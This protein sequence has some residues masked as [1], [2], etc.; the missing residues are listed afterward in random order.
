MK[1]P[2][3]LQDEIY[4]APFVPEIWPRLLDRI[5][6]SIG[7]EGALL[8]NVSDPKLPWIASEGVLDLYTAFFRD[9]WAFDNPRT[10][11]LVNIP[12]RGFMSD[13]DHLNEEW[14]ADQAIYRDFLWPQ[15]FGYA[16]GTVIESPG[17]VT[18]AISIDKRRELGPVSRQDLLY[19]DQLRPHL[20][21]AAI[22]AN[23]LEYAKIEAALHALKIVN[24]P[25]ATIRL[26]GRVLATNHLFE[27]YSGKV[28]IGAQDLLHFS[29]AAI[30]NFYQAVVAGREKRTGKS[31][32]LKATD[33]TP[34][35]ILHFFPIAGVAREIFLQVAYFIIITPASPS[36]GTPAEIIKGLFDLTPTESKIAE[37]L[38]RGELISEIARGEGTTVET[39]RSQVKAILSKSGMA[40]Q[41]DF[42]STLG[43][44]QKIEK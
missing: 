43:S 15:G 33:G 37:R 3:L 29:N 1:E 5:S 7:A 13:A 11:A 20:S 17:D 19:L 24:I 40:S 10:H 28:T 21:R 35:A 44:I 31:F 16:A 34:P 18:V 2:Y 8:A 9:G 4:Q 6:K 25:A 39:V 12:H 27:N 14:M 26:D 22:L 41:R 32:P 42:V 23:R 38:T 30:A 36:N